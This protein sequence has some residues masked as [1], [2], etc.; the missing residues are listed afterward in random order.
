MP[1]C[2]IFT[3]CPAPFGPQCRKPRSASLGGP[4]RPGV[5][6]T[7][8]LPGASEAKIGVSRSTG[9]RS[10][11]QRSEDRFE[12][13]HG[14]ALAADHQ[15]VPTLGTP[16]TAT[17]PAVDVVDALL[18]EGGRVAKVVGVVRVPAVDDRVPGFE[19]LGNSGD[20]R[21]GDPPG[22]D[23][24]PHSARHRQARGEFSQGVGPDRPLR[25]QRRHGGRVDVVDHRRVPVCHEPPGDVGAHATQ[26][27]NAERH[28]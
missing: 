26:A 18:T 19:D 8:S 16:H 7:E 11:R 22:R 3:K 1:L 2:T 21:L 6:G 13:A 23:H 5:R 27:H 20:G 17:R 24:D 15:A 10:R 28:R 12:M 25:D 14:V 9:A 4:E